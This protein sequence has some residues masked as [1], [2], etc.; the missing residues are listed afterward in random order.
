MR[1]GTSVP[2]I[3]P[4]KSDCRLTSISTAYTKGLIKRCVE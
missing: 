3:N 4:D 2:F 1:S